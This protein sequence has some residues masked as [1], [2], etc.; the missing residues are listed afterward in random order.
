MVSRPLFVSVLVSTVIGLG[1]GLGLMKY[2]YYYYYR[3]KRF[4]WRNVK[5][6]QGH[7]TNAKNSDKTRLRRKVR[8]EYLSDEIVGRAVE[9]RKYW[10]W[11]H[12]L[13]SCGF[14]SILCSS[15]VMTSVL[16]ILVSGHY[17]YFTSRK[18]SSSS[19]IHC[20][21]FQIY[22]QRQKHIDLFYFHMQLN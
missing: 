16:L 17:E 10:S 7:L 13:W 6:L 20:L 9:V 2:Y 14:K 3:K 5:R 21:L 22:N 12:T 15:S 8:T 19:I 18:S 4:R 11:S 1:L